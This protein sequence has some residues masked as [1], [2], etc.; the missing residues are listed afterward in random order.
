MYLA[1]C[2]LMILKTLLHYRNSDDI[3]PEAQHMATKK[4][5][6]KKTTGISVK[7]RKVEQK[8][9][10][11]KKTTRK[12]TEETY[13]EVDS[14]EDSPKTRII[15][16]KYIYAVVAVLV[17]VG[18]LFLASQ[19]WVV[20]WVD[21]K[22]VTK[23]ELYSLLEKRDQGKTAEELVVQKLLMSEG[24]KQKQTVS[25][26]EIEAEIKKV[27]EQQGGAAELDQILQVNQTTREEFRKLVELQLVKQKLFGKDINI[28]D[29]DVT[30]YIEENKAMLP[31]AALENPESSEA[32]KLREGVKEQLKQMKINESFNT[33]LEEAM[34]S[35]RVSKNF[36]TA[37]PPPMMQ[38]PQA[39]E[40]PAPQQ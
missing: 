22:P 37:T 32:A 23:F 8:I 4:T 14:S 7:T 17:L 40:A 12:K 31:P 28:T 2:F 5:T 38:A 1:S 26:S 27:E 16:K 36:S 3:M 25:D 11:P 24:Q 18:A 30:K 29:E 6:S 39:P 20:A 34:N 9:S 10:A 19:M 21:N 15:T 33:W 35:P 13:S